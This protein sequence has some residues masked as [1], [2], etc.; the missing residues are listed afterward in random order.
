MVTEVKIALYQDAKHKCCRFARQALQ[1][2]LQM[3]QTLGWHILVE[4]SNKRMMHLKPVLQGSSRPTIS[5]NSHARLR[6][7]THITQLTCVAA[8]PTRAMQYWLEMR[9]PLVLAS[10]IV[11]SNKIVLHLKPVPLSSSRPTSSPNSHA[12]LRTSLTPCSLHVSQ[13]CQ[14]WLCSTGFR[15][16]ILLFWPL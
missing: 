14:H 1:H 11:M 16:T 13:L 4:E 8:L 6:I 7:L 10:S 3:H 12:C 9:L 2:W 15:C 5:Q